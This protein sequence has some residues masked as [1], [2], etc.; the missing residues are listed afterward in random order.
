MFPQRT[1]SDFI[2]LVPKC[3][4]YSDIRPHHLVNKGKCK[5]IQYSC[6][7]YVSRDIDIFQQK[8]LNN[9]NNNNMTPGPDCNHY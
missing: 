1:R 2:C 6:T 4:H 5:Y 8:K 9:N 3:G 7:H